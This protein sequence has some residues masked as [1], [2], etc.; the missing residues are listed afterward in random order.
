MSYDT[1]L[2]SRIINKHD[3]EA[4]WIIASN[5]ANPFI[6]R[7]G[8]Y[9]IYD[10]EY[11]SNGNI[12]TLPAGR[13]IPYSYARVKIGNGKDKVSDLPFTGLS[14]IDV[15]ELPT[16]NIN[17]QAFYRVNKIS[18]CTI[19]AGGDHI[20]DLGE[21]YGITIIYQVVETL[22]SA[23][24][25]TVSDVGNAIAYVY[26]LKNT[27]IGYAT[28][29]NL[30]IF[31]AAQMLSTL[32]DIPFQDHGWAD[33]KED[34]TPSEGVEP[35]Y[36]LRTS[37]LYY[38]SNG[39]WHE[40][41]NNQGTAFVNYDTCTYR[42]IE[43]AYEVVQN[44]GIAYL[45]FTEQNGSILIPM[46]IG[47]FLNTIDS[48]IPI[49]F[50]SASKSS[51]IEEH[52]NH[53]QIYDYSLVALIDQEVTK[54]TNIIDLDPRIYEVYSYDTHATNAAIK[55]ETLSVTGQNNTIAKKFEVTSDN[56][57][58]NSEKVAIKANQ[59]TFTTT[60]NAGS[61]AFKIFHIDNH[62][63]GTATAHV[64]NDSFTTT[65]EYHPQGITEVTCS[66]EMIGWYTTHGYTKENVQAALSEL[67]TLIAEASLTDEFIYF[68]RHWLA[69]QGKASYV[70]S[71]DPENCTITFKKETAADSLYL[72]YR[73]DDIETKY[74]TNPMT[75]VHHPEIGAVDIVFDSI[76]AGDETIVS[77]NNG[78]AAGTGSEVVGK[79]GT[80][81]G[82]AALAGYGAFAAG[83]APEA[84]G[85]ADVALGY[86]PKATKHAGV[87]LGDHVE[88]LSNNQFVYGKYN[89]RDDRGIYAAILGYGTDEANRKNIHTVTRGGTGWFANDICFGGT[90]S[91]DA[92]SVNDT[93]TNLNN[94]IAE[95]SV[96]I[97]NLQKF[98]TDGSVG[99]DYIYADNNTVY[100]LNGRGECVSSDITVGSH[101]FKVPV[102]YVEALAFNGDSTITSLKFLGTDVVIKDSDD[103]TKGAFRSCVNLSSADFTG[104]SEIGWYSF[105][106]NPRL[107]NINLKGV[108]RIGGHAFHDS[109]NAIQIETADVVESIGEG[110]FMNVRIKGD[111]ILP[112]TLDY[113]GVRAFSGIKATTVTF[114]STPSTLYSSA[115]ENC[116]SIT[117]IYV[118]WTE[119]KIAGAPWGATNATI[120]YAEPEAS[121]DTE[122][123]ELTIGNGE[124]NSTNS[125]LTLANATYNADTGELII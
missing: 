66:P 67:N 26:I 62:D 70:L 96:T 55:A 44:G 87:A 25:M 104:V 118:P 30:N 13:S 14:I 41:S 68:N 105:R 112:S 61:K 123:G 65:I 18:A 42:D 22:P 19:N 116:S 8:E 60:A 83:Y 24:D 90:N 85:N 120:H 6:P 77:Q 101:Q 74:L 52:Y 89:E 32:F 50:C 39:Y 97:N 103:Y 73:P 34:I 53:M 47:T 95:M 81:L 115:F 10:P 119:G 71:A 108:K 99:L 20:F 4:N 12:L 124:F 31:T 69:T 45:Q 54:T 78:F 125:E 106:N 2:K 122:T 27:G 100:S 23:S 16:E 109:G 91:S 3:I 1:T 59:L 76:A 98:I 75:F 37:A 21:Y 48:G 79:Y 46:S 38:N 28:I 63:D 35:V 56:T 40:V 80:A 107:N 111:M 11:D 94:T 36:Y 7:N 17:T 102:K 114:N 29:D 121:V 15:D 117:D 92:I 58:I 84:T 64:W 57:T 86:Y 9:V 33:S 88:A 5:A 82:A 93:I 49:Y 113:V 43:A 72:Q 110:A 51:Y